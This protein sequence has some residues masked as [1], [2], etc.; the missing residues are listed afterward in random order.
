MKADVGGFQSR[1]IA[2]G[3]MLLVSITTTTV[4]TTTGQ[5][6]RRGRTL[7]ARFRGERRERFRL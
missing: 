2:T 3:T 6:R 5:R 4:R 7:D 1:S